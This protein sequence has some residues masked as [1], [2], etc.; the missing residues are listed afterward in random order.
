MLTNLF[1]HILTVSMSMAVVIAAAFVLMHLF[2]RNFAARTRY[3]VW[4]ILIL[5]LCIPVGT[6]MVPP[7]FTLEVAPQEMPL[8]EVLP[9]TAVPQTTETEWVT[10]DVQQIPAETR[11]TVQLSPCTTI[12][13]VL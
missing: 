5:R 8:E 11:V 12:E 9:E 4:T 2:G 10:H 6:M 13:P 1:S 7:L 3:L